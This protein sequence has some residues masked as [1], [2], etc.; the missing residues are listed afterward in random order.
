MI[1]E[2]QQHGLQAPAAKAGA[3]RPQTAVM[4]LFETVV[5]SDGKEMKYFLAAAAIAALM[6][7]AGAGT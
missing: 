2:R 5:M 3:A 6:I 4:R 1:I 7:W